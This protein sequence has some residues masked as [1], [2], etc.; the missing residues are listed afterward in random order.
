MAYIRNVATIKVDENKCVGCGIC[1][2]VCP[3]RVLKVS[4]GKAKIVQKDSCIECGACSNNC[5]YGAIRVNK[6]VG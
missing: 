2:K 3:H 6:G 5:K 1:E 4:S